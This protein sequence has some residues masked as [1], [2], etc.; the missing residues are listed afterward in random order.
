M[1]CECIR[2]PKLESLYCTPIYDQN[3]I[4]DMAMISHGASGIENQTS[5]PRV[6]DYLDDKFQNTVDLENIDLLLNGV[7]EQQTL[8]RQQVL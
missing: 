5:N 1:K 2:L 4:V 8:L 3:A 7:L 6:E